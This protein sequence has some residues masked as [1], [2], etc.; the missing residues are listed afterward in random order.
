MA[1]GGG[2]GMAGRDANAGRERGT[3]TRD[4]ANDYG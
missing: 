1:A 3:R 2:G 4:A